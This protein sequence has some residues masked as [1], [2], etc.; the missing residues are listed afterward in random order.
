M[1]MAMVMDLSRPRMIM[2]VVVLVVGLRRAFR[3]QSGLLAQRVQANVSVSVASLSD[4][5]VRE[6][7]E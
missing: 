5:V 6:R 3:L 1:S 4:R 7:I 2:L